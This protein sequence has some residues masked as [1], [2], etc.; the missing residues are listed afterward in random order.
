MAEVVRREEGMASACR[1]SVG[2][3]AKAMFVV[4]IFAVVETGGSGG[5][6]CEVVMLKLV[7][8][9]AWNQAPPIGLS[10]VPGHC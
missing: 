10:D 9:S 8:S 6:G 4:V 1:I 3:R 7:P 2:R 5:V